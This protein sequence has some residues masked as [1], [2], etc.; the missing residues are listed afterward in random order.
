MIPIL[1]SHSQLKALYKDDKA[2]IIMDNTSVVV[3]LGSGPTAL[4]THK[5]ISELLAVHR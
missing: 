2:E 4:S 1:Q 5:W 3:F